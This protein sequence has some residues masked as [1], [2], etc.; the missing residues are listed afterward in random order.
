VRDQWFCQFPVDIAFDR[1]QQFT[2]L[3]NTE[4]L[5]FNRKSIRNSLQL[6]DTVHQWVDPA[7]LRALLSRRRPRPV[8]FLLQLIEPGQ[9]IRMLPL[10]F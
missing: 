1:E 5:V 9:H 7:A 8:N 6:R 10:H 4:L 2:N 3:A